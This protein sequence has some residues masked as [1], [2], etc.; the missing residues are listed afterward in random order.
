VQSLFGSLAPGNSVSS[1]WYIL[2]FFLWGCKCLQ[3]LQSL[4]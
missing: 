1:S 4:P 2:L 3:L